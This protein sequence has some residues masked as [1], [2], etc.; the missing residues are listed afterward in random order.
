MT[1]RALT[2]RWRSGAGE[3]VLSRLRS[4]AGLGDLGLAIHEGR[5]DLRGLA[6]PAATVIRVDRAH[7]RDLDLSHARLPSLRFFDTQLTNCRFDRARCP[8]WRL[9]NSQVSDCA[10]IGTDLRGAALG[11]WHDNR[12]NR[13]RNTDFTTADLRDVQFHG[14][15]LDRCDFARAR[16]DD[17]QFLQSALTGCRFQGRMKEVM[18]DNRL[19]PDEP[20]PEP[21]RQVDFS[22]VTFEYVEFRGCHFIDVRFPDHIR[23]IPHYPAVAARQLALVADDPGLE[24]RMLAAELRNALRRLGDPPDSTG[25]F[26]RRD[27]EADGGTALADLAERSLQAALDEEPD[28]G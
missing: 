9:W 23:L 1:P 19:L 16:L 27:Y 21:L 2:D 17:A 22:A 4:G 18:F 12:H 7:W 14:A 5:V 13:W 10:F 11:T 15:H 20:R 24:G 8:D 28:I 25:V 3:A 6:T 26:N